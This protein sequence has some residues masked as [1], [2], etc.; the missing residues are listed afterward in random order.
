MYR[1]TT[2]SLTVSVEPEYLERQSR[3]DEG[4]FV[5]AYHVRIENHGDE[6]VQLGVIAAEH[7]ST[8]RP[9]RGRLGAAKFFK[10]SVTLQGL[11]RCCD[12]TL[13]E[14]VAT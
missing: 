8:A 11:L 2:R 10:F 9:A 13:A 4:H 7:R 1:E 3:P 5:W 6:T 12:A 14:R